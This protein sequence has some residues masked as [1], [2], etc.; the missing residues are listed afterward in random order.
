MYQNSHSLGPLRSC[1]IFVIS[2]SLNRVPKPQRLLQFVAPKG[3]RLRGLTT[4][5]LATG[6][7]SQGYK[8]GSA[9]PF[10]GTL[11]RDLK[12]ENFPNRTLIETRIDP[13]KELQK[14]TRIYRTTQPASMPRATGPRRRRRAR[15]RH[16]HRACAGG[17]A[18]ALKGVLGLGVPRYFGGF[19]VYEL[20][21]LGT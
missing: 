2:R 7:R 3:E 5:S 21:G 9:A 10:S 1:R 18:L 11:K 12:S 4:G 17:S 6:V 15:R 8:K 14:G 20:R 16:S 19:G 13:F